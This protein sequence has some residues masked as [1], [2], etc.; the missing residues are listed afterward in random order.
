MKNETLSKMEAK[1]RQPTRLGILEI[2]IETKEG[3]LEF[4]PNG[5]AYAVSQWDWGSPMTPIDN[6]KSELS[7]EPAYLV[8]TDNLQLS[9]SLSEIDRFF[10]HDLK[11]REYKKLLEKYGNFYEIS[12]SFYVNSEA[13]Q[14]MDISPEAKQIALISR[15]MKAAEKFKTQLEKELE[16][17]PV[18]KNKIKL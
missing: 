2:Q 11:K 10:R 13:W 18:A 12:G 1:N 17:K 4:D 16:E 6:L 9:L 7:G 3:I 14:P 8:R 5:L 15:K